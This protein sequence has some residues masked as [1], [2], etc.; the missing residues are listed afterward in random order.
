MI[1]VNLHLE[2]MNVDIIGISIFM[3]WFLSFELWGLLII[4]AN[5]DE[6]ITFKLFYFL[7]IPTSIIL[8]LYLTITAISA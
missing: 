5:F 6:K 3:L 7:P 1:R 2:S 8:I 4:I